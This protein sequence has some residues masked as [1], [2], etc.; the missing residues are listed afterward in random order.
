[1][2]YLPGKEKISIKNAQ[3]QSRAGG[4]FADWVMASLPKY[5]TYQTT[6]DVVITT[7]FDPI[8][9]KAAEE[10]VRKVFKNQVNQ[11]SNSQA[12]V[13]IMSAGVERILTLDLHATQIQG[14]FDIPVDNLYAAP[15]F[16]L[17]I[18]HQFSDQFIFAKYNDQN[19]IKEFVNRVDIVTFEF[20]NIPFETLNEL[21]KIINEF[22]EIISEVRGKG[23]MLGIKCKVENTKFVDEARKN[24]M[25]TIKAS[26]NVVRL[27]PPLNISI[28]DCES[29]IS[30]IRKVCKNLS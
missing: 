2:H 13:V 11:H 1:M 16:A 21:N 4:Y 18:L 25:L 28:E 6:E 8:I 15:V 27:L 23:L 10:A 26:D 12:A 22:P 19:K 29:A 14:F 30:I 7:T 24:K 17:D 3:K 9:Q 5:L 20:E